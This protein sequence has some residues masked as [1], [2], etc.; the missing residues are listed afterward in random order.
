M[1]QTRLLALPTVTRQASLLFWDTGKCMPA[2]GPLHACLPFLESSFFPQMP[3]WVILLL[4]PV[5]L[6]VTSNQSSLL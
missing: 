4:Y 5:L 6:A 1:A 3:A 2:S